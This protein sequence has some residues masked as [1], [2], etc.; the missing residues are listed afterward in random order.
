M[1]Q[2]NSFTGTG[3]DGSWDL[4]SITRHSCRNQMFYLNPKLSVLNI[5]FL[6]PAA[7]SVTRKRVRKRFQT[8]AFAE[9]PVLKS[10]FF[11]IFYITFLDHAKSLPFCVSHLYTSFHRSKKGK[12]GVAEIM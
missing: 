2:K 9:D 7:L 5:F 4:P 12:S 3:V 1:I 10:F 8:P 11:P 6:L